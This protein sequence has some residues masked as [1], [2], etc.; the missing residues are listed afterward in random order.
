MVDYINGVAP[1][2]FAIITSEKEEVREE[3]KYLSMGEGPHYV[4]YRPYHLTSLETPLSVARAY[5]E[6]K[7]T[8]APY[9]G[10]IAE[11]VAVAKKDLKAGGYLDAIGGF[12]VYG[13]VD[14]YESA[15][16]E[17]A[18]PIGLVGANVKLKNDIKKDHVLTY[19]DV[20]LE[21][22]SFLWELRKKQDNM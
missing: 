12:T 20:E 16:N 3:M 11:T 7:P 15:K 19:D 5:F 2:V 17:K 8:I 18:L 13:K 14:E 6:N 21:G 22:E 10:M 9:H 4:L 1:G